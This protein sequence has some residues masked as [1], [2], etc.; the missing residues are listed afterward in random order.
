MRGPSEVVSGPGVDAGADDLA[1]EIDVD[2]E[3]VRTARL[4]AGAT[5]R[6]YG[7][8]EETVEDLKVAISEAVTNAIR[9]HVAA[10]MDDPILVRATADAAA[11]RFDVVDRGSTNAI[12]ATPAEGGDYTPPAGLG[13]STLGMVVISALFPSVEITP[14]GDG[15]ATISIR[16]ERPPAS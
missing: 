6:H 9:S 10:G 14:D 11:V 15:G 7:L 13:A 8:D 2:P 4:F 1:L 5:A 3:Q 16:I 12:A